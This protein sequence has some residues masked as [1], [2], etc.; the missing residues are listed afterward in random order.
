P[1][2]FGSTFDDFGEQFITDN[3]IHI[4]H[5]VIPMR[6][7][8]RAPLLDVRAESQDISDHGLHSSRMYPLTG[9][10]E[11]RKV[12]TEMRRQRQTENN[13][14]ATEEVSGWFTAA[15]GGTLYNGDAF[16]KEYLNSVFTG[17]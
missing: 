15:S 16:P 4:R 2:Q 1:A 7:L 3:T 13:K 6:Y 17:D 9:P 12:R 10:R 14:K 8:K 11:W 5:V